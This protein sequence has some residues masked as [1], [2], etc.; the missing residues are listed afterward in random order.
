[1]DVAEPPVGGVTGVVRVAEEAAGGVP[2]QAAVRATGELK[3]PNDETMIADVTVEPA[4]TSTVPDDASEKSAA[5]GEMT[6]NVRVAEC[7]SGPAVPVMVRGYVPT[8]TLPGTNIVSV[9]EAVPPAVAVT[10][11]ALK[12]P[13]I[14]EAAEYESVTGDAKL[15]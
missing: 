13:D 4:L 1:V 6:Y 15:F 2:T 10:V 7:V 11:F 3:L 8:G 5:V 14:P 9:D 12:L